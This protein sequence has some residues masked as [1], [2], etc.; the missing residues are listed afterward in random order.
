MGIKKYLTIRV[1]I[2]IAALLG[3]LL[4]ISPNPFAKGIAVKT[5][6][7]NSEIYNEGLRIN[8]RIISIDK[9]LI[10][11]IDDFNSKINEAFDVK[12]KSITIE[13]D[14]GIKNYKYL[15]SPGFRT[16]NLTVIFA[17]DFTN[18]SRG[19]NITKINNFKVND[20]RDLDII[21]KNITETVKLSIKTDKKNIIY[22]A[23]EK[24]KFKVGAAK[25]TNIKKGLDLEGGTRV[26]LKPIKDSEELI[27]DREVDDLIKV[28]G[29]RLDVYGLSDLKI[30]PAKSFLSDDRFVLIEIGGVTREEIADL[31]GKQGKFEAKIGDVVVFEG[32]K[33]D[34]TFVCRNDGSCSGITPPQRIDSGDYLTR[35]QFQIKLSPDAA[36]KQGLT[37]K[38]LTVN[39]TEEGGYLSKNLDLYLDGEL[40]DSL[41][42]GKDLRGNERATDILISGPGYGRSQEES[43]KEALKS[44]EKLQTILITGSLPLDIKIEKLDSISPLAG[45]AFL[46]NAMIIGILVFIGVALV[47]YLRYRKLKIA[48]LILSTSF[49]EVIIILGFASI[50]GWSLDLAAIAG[51]IAAIGTGV[52]SQIVIVDEIQKGAAGQLNWK[53][54]IKNAFFIIFAAYS[55]VVVAMLP[56]FSAGAGLVRG[57]AITTIIGVSIGVFITRPA[58]SSLM[59]KLSE[60]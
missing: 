1:I 58:F 51:I 3:S 54:R 37:T 43:G 57:F 20:Q 59:E 35:F 21:V 23:T 7:R 6:D 41:R 27:T 13:T 36:K 31:I 55:T 5:I 56:L 32:G 47:L 53:Q 60:E 22:L 28:L 46:K 39:A 2:L 34:V 50:I 16:D 45:E 11:S 25:T 30:R 40:I 52:D 26:L 12:E 9:D 29:N 38:N 4:T 10:N 15:L 18:L 19:E 8:D 14:K 17:E 24:P 33:K 42:I 48:F 49:F 44:M